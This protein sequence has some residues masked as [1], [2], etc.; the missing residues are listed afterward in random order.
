MAAAVEVAP[1][2]LQLLCVMRALSAVRREQR[3]CVLC[4]RNLLSPVSPARALSQ[5]AKPPALPR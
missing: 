5:S 3:C 2:S 1:L 4:V